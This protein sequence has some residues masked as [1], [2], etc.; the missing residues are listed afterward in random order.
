M[1][2]IL[3]TDGTYKNS[4]AALRSLGK[5]NQIDITSS[6]SRFLSLCSYS[7]YSRN[8]FKIM[9][10]TKD[11]DKYAAELLDI[12]KKKTYDVF[13]PVGLQSY[14]AA[15]KH[16]EKFEKVTNLVIPDW[17]QMIIASNKEQTM[18]FAKKIGIPIPETHILNTEE[19]LQQITTY[20]VVIKSSDES[21]KFIR[22]CN[23]FS[24]LIIR[25]HE[26]ATIAQTKIITQEYIQG[27]GCGFYGVY[28][29]GE[30]IAHFLHKRL[31]E[32]PITGG[33]SAVAES[34]FDKKLYAY[35][36]LL[37][38]KLHWNGPIMAEFKY[39]ANKND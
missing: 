29:N 15:S 6:F 17:K 23:N 39:N 11:T 36:K 5:N 26:L 28:N 8:F 2:T 16:K 4:L 37:C 22:Y 25:Y 33:P 12:L 13:L 32:F 34:Y 7:K 9:C 31:K 24:E 1:Q 38:D 19:D 27:F 30:L 18:N 14:L 21:G 20:P 3:V 10:N 35:G